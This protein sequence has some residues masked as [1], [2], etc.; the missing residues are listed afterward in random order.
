MS[1]PL[2]DLAGQNQPIAEELR[3]VFNRVLESGRF[4]LGPEVQKFEEQISDLVNARHAIG[5]S[6]GTDALLVALMTLDV[7]PGDEVI[8]PAFT[9]FA[10]AGCIARTGATPVFVDSCPNCFNLDIDDVERKIS[11]RTKAI[12]PVHLF[13][14][15]A[16]MDRL[17][18]LANQKGLAVIEDAAQSIGASYRE[19]KLGSIGTFGTYSFFPSKNL[20]GFGDGGMLVCNDDNLADKAR[21]LRGH[22][23]SP[24]YYHRYVGGNFRLDALQA[25]LLGVKLP[26]YSRYTMARQKNAAR[27]TETLAQID[28]IEVSDGVHSTCVTCVQDQSQTPSAAADIYLP[29]PYAHCEHIWNQY[30]L[31]VLGKGKRDSLRGF[32]REREIGTEVYYPLPLHQQACFAHLPAM[33]LPNAEKLASEC[34]SIPVYPGLSPDHQQQVVRA[35]GDF[36]EHQSV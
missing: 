8:C 17:M 18:A 31:R 21:K 28:G 13:G 14:Q 12:I 5:V 19:K 11:S 15:S 9:F 1:V 22:G 36:L 2:L 26:H 7:G 30:T 32:L 34:I 35:I 24:K 33:S 6:S 23:S 27:Y 20:G 29:S 3:T 4:I 16:E 25:A 10:T